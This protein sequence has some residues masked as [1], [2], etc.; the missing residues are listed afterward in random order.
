M[1]AKNLKNA[2][3]DRGMTQAEI[4]AATGI[5]KSG[6]SQYLSGK[7]TPGPKAL[8]MIA[9]ALNVPEAYLTGKCENADNADELKPNSLSV[10]QAAKLMNKCEQFIRVGLQRGILPFGYAVKM[11]THYTYYISSQK[12]TEYTGIQ[13]N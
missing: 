1:F 6:I 7:F 11:S 4:V 10:G 12:F 13:I 8:K 3:T 9:D 5:S 2:M